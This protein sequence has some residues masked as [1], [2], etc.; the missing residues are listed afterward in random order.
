ML[1]A[2]TRLGKFIAMS[3]NQ[4]P[5]VQGLTILKTQDDMNM[6]EHIIKW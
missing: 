3:A 6:K 4:V 2:S 5:L 1:A